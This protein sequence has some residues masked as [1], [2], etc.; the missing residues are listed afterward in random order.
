[1]TTYASLFMSY[2]SYFLLASCVLVFVFGWINLCLSNQINSF[3][4]ITA[5]LMIFGACSVGGNVVLPMVVS[6]DWHNYGQAAVCVAI[7]T[8]IAGERQRH[9][10]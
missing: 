7:V 2:S 10:C 4:A 5:L 9:E 1:M 3:Q 6:T 8:W